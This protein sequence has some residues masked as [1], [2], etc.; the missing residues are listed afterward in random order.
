MILKNRVAELEEKVSKLNSQLKTRSKYEQI[1][2]LMNG[3]EYYEDEKYLYLVK[4]GIVWV[5]K[6]NGS[7][8]HTKSEL[9]QHVKATWK[10]PELL[11]SLI[12]GQKRLQT[13]L[14]DLLS[15]DSLE[16]EIQFSS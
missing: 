6:N 7:Y 9:D 16:K 15:K 13:K 10:S 11:H 14:L 3:D 8:E 1:K 4:D 12:L 5:M 2:H